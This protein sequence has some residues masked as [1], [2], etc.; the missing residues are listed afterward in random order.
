[1]VLW[2]VINVIRVY[3]LREVMGTSLLGVSI[4][5]SVRIRFVHIR[6]TFVVRSYKSW[7]VEI[8]VE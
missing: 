7:S 1:M 2:I 6:F 3:G 5:K 4:V 8:L